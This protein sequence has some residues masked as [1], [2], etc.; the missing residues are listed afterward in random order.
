MSPAL[1]APLRT[2]TVLS[3]FPPFKTKVSFPLEMQQGAK[4]SPVLTVGL[5]AFSLQYKPRSWAP[6]GFTWWILAM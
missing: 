2:L 3:H 4:A 5:V 6:E 1:W